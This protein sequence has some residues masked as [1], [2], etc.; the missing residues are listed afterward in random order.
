[1][2]ITMAILGLKLFVANIGSCW[3]DA[4]DT[5]IK[6]VFHLLHCTM[7]QAQSSC[8]WRALKPF[9]DTILHLLRSWEY[10]L[11]PVKE[12]GAAMALGEQGQKWSC[13]KPPG[14]LVQRD[15]LSFVHGET[16]ARRREV[17]RK[18]ISQ[19]PGYPPA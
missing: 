14:T 19:T 8:Q 16:K 17:T 10:S 13:V 7:D 6:G 15:A 18:G 11:L 2:D 1:M 9:A 3:L 12:E 5:E 4:K